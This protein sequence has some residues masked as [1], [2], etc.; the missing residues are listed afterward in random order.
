MDAVEHVLGA[1]SAWLSKYGFW[2]NNREWASLFWL[3]IL[4]VWVLLEA[5]RRDSLG[6]AIRLAI[7][8]KLLIVWACFIL[9]ISLFLVFAYWQHLWD[10]RLTKDTFVWTATAGLVLLASFTNAH[11]PGFF[12]NAILKTV[13][14]AVWIEYLLTLDD[15]PLFVEV[16]LQPLIVVFAAAPFVVK[17]PDARKK[18]QI[19]SSLFFLILFVALFVNTAVFLSSIWRSLDWPLFWLRAVWPVTLGLWVL[20]LVFVWGLVASYERAFVRL[21]SARPRPRGLWKAKVG[22]I[23]A[24]GCNLKWI[25]RAAQGGTYHVARAKSVW[26]AIQAAREFKKI[27]TAEKKAEQSYHANLRRFAGNLGS[28]DQGRPLDKREFR[29]TR[30]ALYWLHTCQMGWFPRDPIGYKHD[31][32]ERFGDDFTHQGLSI[33]SGIVMKVADDRTKWYAWRRTIGGHHFA[34]GASGDPPN[35]WRYDGRN[36]PTGFPGI[37]QEWGKSPF[38]DNAGPNWAEL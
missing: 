11:M 24:L 15:F 18:V 7:A 35:Q 34:I 33:P 20:L 37:A 19:W 17:A 12:R 36:P 22:L 29:E 38:D 16:V 21:E 4:A 25:H 1:I 13:G 27:R 26:A 32:L 3:A 14:I 30:K 23:S 5:E 10:A 8:P 9:W 28:D 6:R 2:L 31:L